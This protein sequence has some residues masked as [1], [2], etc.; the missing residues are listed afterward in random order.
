MGQLIENGM[1]AEICPDA[2]IELYLL[3]IRLF[4]LHLLSLLK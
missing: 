4:C 1:F 2:E 3:R